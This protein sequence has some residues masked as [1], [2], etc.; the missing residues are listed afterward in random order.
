MTH[1]SQMKEPGNEAKCRGGLV[2]VVMHPDISF[3]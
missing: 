3:Q 1:S 2:N